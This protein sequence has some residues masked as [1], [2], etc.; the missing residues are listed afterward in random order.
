MD[1]LLRRGREFVAIDV[2]AGRVFSKHA[3]RG[4]K[5][6]ADVRGVV[7]RVLVYSGDRALRTAGGIDALPINRF[8]Q[9]MEEGT[10]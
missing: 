7:R 2:K 4:L 6:V 5:A 3:A 10:L 8:A 9:E 1:F